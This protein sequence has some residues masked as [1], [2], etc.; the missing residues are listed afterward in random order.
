M[1]WLMLWVPRRQGCAR[2]VEIPK[3]PVI[4]EQFNSLF[5]KWIVLPGFFFRFWL[6]LEKLQMWHEVQV[7]Y[8]FGF[9]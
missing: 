9:S 7:L 4:L 5:K 8:H 2:L 6:Q 3:M 1:N